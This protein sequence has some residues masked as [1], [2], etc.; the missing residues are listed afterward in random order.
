[1][2]LL[3]VASPLQGDSPW[4]HVDASGRCGRP[5]ASAVMGVCSRDVHVPLAFFAVAC[6]SVAECFNPGAAPPFL[7]PR[8]TSV[9]QS[10]SPSIHPG[11]D[12]RLQSAPVANGGTRVRL[13]IRSIAMGGRGDKQRRS[14]NVNP[15]S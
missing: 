1:M 3:T 14:E 9:R 6:F 12:T 2:V 15:K 7:Q 4:A 5:L 8:L 10:K 11:A 13:G